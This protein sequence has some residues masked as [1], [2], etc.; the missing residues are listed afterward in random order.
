MTHSIGI[1]AHKDRKGLALDLSER[2]DADMISIDDGYLGCDT[3]HKIV[4]KNLLDFEAQWL[5]V[6]EDD[7]VPVPD[8]RGQLDDMLQASP[9]NVVGLYLGRMRQPKHQSQIF[10]ATQQADAVDAHWIVGTYCFNTVGIAIRY[11]LVPEMLANLQAYLP[12]DQAIG[13][14]LRTKGHTIAYAWPSPLD[15]ADLP[16]LVQ[17]PDGRERR[18]GRVAWHFGPRATWTSTSVDLGV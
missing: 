12:I 15:H 10:A 13:R 5:V 18:P 11:S 17:H 7:A 3:N 2:V 6:L 8:L 16:T 9:T 4:W 14:W 1:V